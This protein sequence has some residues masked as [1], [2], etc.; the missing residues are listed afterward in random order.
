M[1]VSNIGAEA[2]G[3]QVRTNDENI[4]FYKYIGNWIL[5]L[6]IYRDISGNIGGYFDKK[7]SMNKN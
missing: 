6:R 4:S 3:I 7:I 1:G 5:M 2:K